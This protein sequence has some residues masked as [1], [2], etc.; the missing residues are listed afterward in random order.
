MKRS[1]C[2]I[3]LVLLSACLSFGQTKRFQL[4]LFGGIQPTFAYGSAADYVLGSNDFPVTPAH[5]P[6]ALGAA[7][8]FSLSSRLALELRGEYILASTMTLTDPS[9]RDTVSLKSSKHMA[10][11]LNLVWEISGGG[12]RP[13]LVLGGGV[14]KLSG[15]SVTAMSK[16]GYDVTFAAP[17]KTLSLM[18]NAGGGLRFR[19]SPAL[20]FQ[21]DI[22][23]RLLFSSPDKIRGLVGGAGLLWRF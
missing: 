7:L 22:R 5:T 9:D 16:Y 2:L 23:Y 3:V 8:S 10:A 13:F 6:A 18:A 17:G 11:A 14:D 19:L 21:L 20:G 12:I 4:A 1:R 15:D